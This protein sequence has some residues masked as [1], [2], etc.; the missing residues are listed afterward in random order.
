M[1]QSPPTFTQI[2][3]EKRSG[4]VPALQGAA[5]FLSA[6]CLTWATAAAGQ[7]PTSMA[8]TQSSP[9]SDSSGVANSGGLQSNGVEPGNDNRDLLAGAANQSPVGALSSDQIANI[10]EQNPDLLAELRAQLAE[11]MTQQGIPIEADDISDQMIYNQVAT[12]STLRADITAVLQARGYAASGDLSAAGAQATA[13]PMTDVTPALDGSLLTSDST[14]REEGSLSGQAV[15][16]F[17][18]D[19]V[20]AP[21]EMRSDLNR[22]RLRQDSRGNERANASTDPPAAIHQPTPLAL[23]S[24]RDLYTQVPNDTKRLERFGSDV[25]VSRAASVMA[26]GTSAL[27][28]PPDVP[29]GPDY[30]LGAGDQLTIA[31]WGGATESL[32]RTVDREGRV[33]LPEAGVLQIAGL[34]LE[35]AQALITNA[36]KQQYRNAQVA[37]TVSGL[38]SVRV[39]VVGDVQRPGG[40]DISSLA[41]PLSALYAAGGPTA[42]GSLRML[43]HYRGKQLV[44]DVDLY[45]FLLHGLRGPLARFQS[46]D[47]LL[48]PPAGP[49]VAISG[50]VK[51]EA[52]YELKA[53]ETMLTAVI[54]DAGGLT[55]AASLNHMRIERIDANHQRVTVT[56]PSSGPAGTSVGQDA[57]AHFE[58]RDGDRIRVE[59]ILSYSQRAVYLAGHVVRPG[60]VPYTDGMRLSEVIR[61]YQDLLPEPAAHGEIVRLMPPD[62]HAEAIEFD[63]PD[64]MIGNSNLDLQPFDTIRVFGRYQADAPTATIRGEVMQPGTYPLSK[65]MTAAQLVRMAGGF[66]RDALL[67]SADL[68]SYEVNGGNQVSENIATVR[69]GAAVTGTDPGADVSLRAGDILAIHQITNW[70]DIGESVTVLGQVKYPGSY[71]FRDGEHLSAVLRR[72]GGLLPTA[73]AIGAVLIRE[74]VKTLEQSSRDELIRQIETN[75]AAAR[76]SPN[77][78]ASNS[79]GALQ[80]IK[81][82]QEEIIA[83][84]QS[85][86]PTGRMVIHITADIDSWAN[87][88]ADVELR[89]NDELTIPKEPGFVLVTGQVYNATALTFT[90][91]KTAAWY[92]GHAGGTNSTANRKEIFIIRA[93]GSVVGR[94]SG[95]AF[96]GD[97]LSTRLNAGDVVVVP[98]KLVGGSLF[99][100]NVLATGQLAASVAVSAGVA[101][102]TL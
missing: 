33:F 25:F 72:A 80:L 15:A 90:P 1:A 43:Q 22:Q 85:H 5:A 88:P 8:Q 45:D 60:R 37:V 92:L 3:G 78:S 68:T 7:F 42:V 81:A 2:V 18:R 79:P 99:W 31:L 16:R 41:T 61:S 55:A 66:K 38:R 97:V 27:N 46:G 11:R 51:R 69:I 50:A 91:G 76:L 35:R 19:N 40:F 75:A 64:V 14:A 65:G 29:L 98:Q 39:Y 59:P 24:M 63:V 4:R 71:G 57:M 67:E 36:L 87:T 12:N 89:K 96:G 47:T 44:E 70:A 58:V 13:G 20:T 26:R 54:D 102:A 62:L 56:L 84:L 82:Q 77:I 83:N 86:P 28:S 100:R 95:G 10:L 34:P 48:V 101:A 94:N 30:I 6:F 23:Q 93:N 53:G 74:Q 21:V 52:I 73:Y 17:N 32:A 49:Q 9:Q